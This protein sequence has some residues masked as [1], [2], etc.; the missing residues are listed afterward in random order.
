MAYIIIQGILAILTNCLIIIGFLSLIGKI[1]KV[2][3]KLKGIE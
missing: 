2:N 1:F 3:E